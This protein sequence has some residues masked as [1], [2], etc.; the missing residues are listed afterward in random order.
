MGQGRIR[1][2]LYKRGLEQTIRERGWV[3]C[4][5]CGE[6]IISTR[7]LTIDHDLPKKWGGDSTFFNLQPAHYK[8]N[9]QKGSKLQ[10]GFYEAKGGE[11][12]V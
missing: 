3:M 1:R 12:I 6:K 10:K 7:D 11:G 8:C 2:T 9:Q 4:H 5:L